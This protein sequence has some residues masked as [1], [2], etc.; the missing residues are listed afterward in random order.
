M[1]RSDGFRTMDLPFS[2]MVSALR[3]G[4]NRH[5]SFVFLAVVI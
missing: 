3:F 4:R 1:A 2:V 5:W